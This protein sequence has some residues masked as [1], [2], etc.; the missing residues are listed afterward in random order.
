MISSPETFVFF[1]RSGCGKGTQVR[2]LMDFLSKNDPGRKILYTETGKL[3]RDFGAREKS[4]G[5]AKTKA[6]IDDGGL[7]PEYVPICI[8]GNYLMKNVVG[9]EHMVFDGVSRRV[10]EAPILHSALGFFERKSRH[11]I[12][13]NVSDKWSMDRL[14]ARSKTEGRADD[15]EEGIK[16]RLKWFDDSVRST[17]RYFENNPDYKFHEINGEQTIEQVHQ[18]ILKK[19]FNF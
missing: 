14:L 16:C 15:D 19:I 1:G 4:F 3:L 12:L 10:P 8:W 2:L 9:D 6:I 5:A 7:L 11:I 18:E 17:I 13:I